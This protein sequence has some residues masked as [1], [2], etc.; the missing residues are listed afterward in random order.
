MWYFLLNVILGLSSLHEAGYTGAGQ[1]IAVIDGGF[2]LADTLYADAIVDAWD[3]I[4]EA[5]I[6]QYGDLYSDPLDAHGTCCLSTILGR[7]GRSGT[8]PDAQV[9]LFRTEERLTES[10]QEMD[11]LAQAIRMADSLDVDVITI[12]LGYY[13]FDDTTTNFTYDDMDGVTTSAAIAAAEV[14]QRRIICVAAGN[15]GSQSWHYMLTPADA[16]NI[17][18]VGATDSLGQSAAFSSYGPSADGRQKPEVSAWGSQTWIWQSNDWRKGN[19]TSFATPEIAGMM[20]CLRQALPTLS[21]KEMREA[22]IRSCDRYTTPD[23]RVGYG[24]PNAEQAMHIATGITLHK[25][26]E[27]MPTRKVL[28]DG[29][30]RIIVAGQERDILGRVQ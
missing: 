14:G 19:G 11:R 10:R 9:Y 3:M 18:T 28:V 20:A 2:Y 22:V 5:S 15:M 1:K 21:A 4:P 27:Q 6:A 7:R 26:A 24:V 12:S 30:L 17:L 8:A 25:H 23:Y 29:Q 16:E 13:Q